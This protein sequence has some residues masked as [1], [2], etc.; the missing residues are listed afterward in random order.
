M[1]RAQDAASSILSLQESKLFDGGVNQRWSAILSVESTRGTHFGSL[2][3]T[4]IARLASQASIQATNLS[5]VHIRRN[6]ASISSLRGDL[7]TGPV[8]DGHLRGVAAAI[9]VAYK[10]NILIVIAGA[11][12]K[13]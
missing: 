1:F 10:I 11:H 6:D 3:V 5:E 8:A 12:S 7:N 2:N 13:C 4:T 9:L